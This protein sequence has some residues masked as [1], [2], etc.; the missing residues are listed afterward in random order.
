M[1]FLPFKILRVRGHSMEPQFK[2]GSYVLVRLSS[3]SSLSV[4]DVIVLESPNG[5][6]LKRIAAIN[7]RGYQVTGDNPNDSYDSRDFGLIQRQDIIG[8]VIWR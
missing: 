6:M 2:D 1:L 7:E 3:A 5:Q 8:N 4:G